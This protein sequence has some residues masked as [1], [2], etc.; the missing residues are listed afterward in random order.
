MRAVICGDSHIGAVFGLG[1][2]N[3]SGGNTRVDDYEKTLN[4]IID[5]TISTNADI[6]IQT[7]DLF[8]HRDPTP[9]HM[10]IVDKALKRLSNAN[11]ATFVIMGNHDYKKS[12]TE[13]TSSITSLAASEYPNVRMLLEPEIVEVCNSDNEK[14]NLLL[15]PYRDK[16]MYSGSDIREQTDSYNKHIVELV[17]N[18]SNGLPTIAVGHNFFF[19]GSYNDY[20]GSEVMAFPGSF[21]GC[22]VAIMGHLHHFRVLQKRAPVCIYSGAMERSNFGDA[23]DDKY[24][25]DY[26][27]FDKK[28]KF[29]KSNVRDLVDKEVDL[30]DCDFSNVL[31]KLSDNISQEDFKDKIVRL[32]IS[33]DEK[34]LPAVDKQFI[35]KEL[36][37]LGA[38]YVSKITVEPITKRIVR[39]NAILKHK[40]DYSMLKA[41][42]QS[43]DIESEYL[44]SLLE[45]AK[46]IM[47]E[48]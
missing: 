32:K 4:E 5:Y 30:V 39:D 29:C 37:K 18:S 43:Q 27:F 33:V 47:E 26:S 7:G 25:I 22:D 2:P 31:D 1:R 19:E 41:F 45:E 40:D 15:V 3:G 21:N 14:V 44:D 13:F 10:K 35:Q 11:V 16:R 46:K 17:K 42:L 48:K 38:F 36:Y 8:E 12:G 9:Q 20:G 34:I 6:F 24:Y 28:I 23:K